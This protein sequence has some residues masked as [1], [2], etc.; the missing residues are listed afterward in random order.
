MKRPL[1]QLDPRCTLIAQRATA[2]SRTRS[3]HLN[4][5]AAQLAVILQT[6]HERTPLRLQELLEADDFN[7][8]HDVFG[9]YRF[10]TPVGPL[11]GGFRPRFSEHGGW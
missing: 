4:V 2:V 10:F 7:F 1:L 5:D 11:K 9:I 8:N 3:V 6:V